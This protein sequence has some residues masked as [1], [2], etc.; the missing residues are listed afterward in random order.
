[1][2]LDEESSLEELMCKLKDNH[3]KYLCKAL[4]FALILAETPRVAMLVIFII[5]LYLQ[6]IYNLKF[7]PGFKMP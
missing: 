5:W 1:M 7:S 3:F 4:E 6:K 2:A